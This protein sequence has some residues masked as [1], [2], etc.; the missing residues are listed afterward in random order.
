MVE[1]YGED[2]GEMIGDGF[3]DITREDECDGYLCLYTF[4]VFYIICFPLWDC[5]RFHRSM[6][7]NQKFP[8]CPLALVVELAH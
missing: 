3:V 4:F 6:I 5:S 2:D 8:A 1:V 7:H